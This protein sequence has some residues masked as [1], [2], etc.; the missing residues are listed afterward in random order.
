MTPELI[1]ELEKQAKQANAAKDLHGALVRIVL[2]AAGCGPHCTIEFH[3][4]GLQSI[5][6]IATDVLKRHPEFVQ[7]EFPSH[8]ET[9]Q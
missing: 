7:I 9:D 4:W 8:V 3:R 1:A 6:K 5:T 2:E